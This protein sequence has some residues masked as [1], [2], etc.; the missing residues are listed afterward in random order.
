MK[1]SKLE[2]IKGKLEASALFF[3]FGVLA[4]VLGL[5]ISSMMH[6]EAGNAGSTPQDTTMKWA[7]TASKTF[8]QER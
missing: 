8:S 5:L 1:T 6:V 3:A 7:N 2:K 4:F